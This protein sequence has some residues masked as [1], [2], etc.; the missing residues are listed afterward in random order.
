MKP[1]NLFTILVASL[2]F[3]AL[4]TTSQAAFVSF[5]EVVDVYALA[6]VKGEYQTNVFA[7]E[8]NEQDDFVFTLSPG[9]EINVGRNT[10]ARLN[11][12]YIHNILFYVERDNLNTHTPTVTLTGN[13]SGSRIGLNGGVTYR[14][15]QQ[16]QPDDFLERRGFNEDVLIRNVFGANLG[17]SYSIT[18]KVNV[19]AG[20]NYSGVYYENSDAFDD[21]YGDRYSFAGS[22][23]ANY[24]V[25]PKLRVGGLYRYRYEFN[26]DIGFYDDE[27]GSIRI[28]GGT[29]DGSDAN[30]RSDFMD[31][32]IGLTAQGEVTPKLSINAD[33]GIGIRYATDDDASNADDS[34]GLSAGVDANY[35]ATEK[36]TARL[37]FDAGFDT[38]AAGFSTM[39]YTPSVG[40]NYRISNRVSAN[41][42]A[43]YR[44]RD[45]ENIDRTDNTVGGTLGANYRIGDYVTLGGNYS[46]TQ[47]SSDGDSELVG[48]DYINHRF[49]ITASI[50][51]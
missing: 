40:A 19:T 4:A 26:E 38:S 23:G 49:S 36:L 47:S 15:L 20:F 2:G 25:R 5:G 9:L 41:A 12:R 34:V 16:N 18:Q 1:T 48:R 11:L 7:T 51:Y 37:M 33:A 24:A 32:F 22:L 28:G 31:H 46:V 30:K 3:A 39:V 13:W 17:A 14:R 44:I 42:S 8:D 29:F 6:S 21:L 43:Y 35:S 45:Y 10:N 50:R 27:V